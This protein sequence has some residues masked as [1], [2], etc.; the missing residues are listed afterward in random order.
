MADIQ[1]ETASPSRHLRFLMDIRNDA[2][3]KE[4]E[5]TETDLEQNE[6][7]VLAQSVIHKDSYS[8]DGFSSRDDF[9]SRPDISRDS[10]SNKQ[11]S[12]DSLGS[13]VFG[14][15][16]DV[17][18]QF[19]KTRRSKK[20]PDVLP[21]VPDVASLVAMF[22][23]PN[24]FKEVAQRNSIMVDRE[25]LDDFTLLT[26]EKDR[27]K[28]YPGRWRYYIWLVLCTLGML[29][30]FS[31]AFILI[32][33]MLGFIPSSRLG[34]KLKLYC[35]SGT[36]LFLLY[37]LLVQ[38][39]IFNQFYHALRWLRNFS[40]FKLFSV[41]RNIASRSQ[42]RPVFQLF[43][44][45]CLFV[46]IDII[47]TSLDCATDQEFKVDLFFFNVAKDEHIPRTIAECYGVTFPINVIL[48]LPVLAYG[49]ASLVIAQYIKCHARLLDRFREKMQRFGPV[50]SLRIIKEKFLWRQT[51]SLL[52]IDNFI[53]HI[54][55]F[56]SG[57]VLIYSNVFINGKDND[58][59]NWIRNVIEILRIGIIFL[60]PWYAISA[61]LIKL[62]SSYTHLRRDVES[63][64]L[65]GDQPENAEFGW[66]VTMGVFY[67]APCRSRGYFSHWH[68]VT[69]DKYWIITVTLSTVMLIFWNIVG[70]MK[71]IRYDEENMDYDHI[72]CDQWVIALS[73]VC[74]MIL[75]L[76][77]LMQQPK[78]RVGV[79][80]KQRVSP[81]HT[82]IVII[83]GV[84]V[85]LL[86]SLIPVLVF[87]ITCPTADDCP[88]SHSNFRNIS[89]IDHDHEH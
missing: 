5:N 52:E 78:A 1:E 56:G 86:V 44:Y 71:G 77:F 24:P 20:Q 8:V 4:R 3:I 22:G 64:V 57:T 69:I 7:G 81:E 80:S 79:V 87:S 28:S 48:F 73:A 49:T 67:T 16:Q 17:G 65:Q 84:I 62:Q 59:L 34:D 37:Y 21:E 39:V 50:K 68:G 70:N 18:L 9:S 40:R 45:Y 26:Q 25:L 41:R 12:E 14:Q 83:I 11:A 2:S 74:G 31:Y 61:A 43:L 42:M 89:I 32:V 46:G 38:F 53:I 63:R 19:V 13:L 75:M 76:T 54:M 27:F 66:D 55:Y 72:K 29:Y 85:L 30:C 6:L 35:N 47:D 15:N 51:D 60:P 10:S 23:L 33:C 58:F 82:K 88:C 36:T